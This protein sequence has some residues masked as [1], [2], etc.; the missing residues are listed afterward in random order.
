LKSLYLAEVSNGLSDDA[1]LACIEVDLEDKKI[2][3][4]MFQSM[5][6]V[7]VIDSNSYDIYTD[8][9]FQKGAHNKHF[10]WVDPLSIKV[11]GDYLLSLNRNNCELVVL[12][13]TSLD[14][15]EIF[16]LG[17]APN[18]PRDVEMISDMVIISYPERNGLII[19]DIEATSLNKS[20]QPTA[21]AS[22]D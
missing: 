8:I 12:D 4:G 11:Y 6:G 19:L 17:E 2:Y 1:I 15:I 9:R 21:N 20:T 16:Y 13:K 5:R 7:C 18:G 3:V 22:T 10:N 14:I